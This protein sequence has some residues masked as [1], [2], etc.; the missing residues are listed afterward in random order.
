MEIGTKKVIG[1]L[2]GAV[3]FASASIALWGYLFPPVPDN[4]ILI[5]PKDTSNVS[6]TKENN[7]IDTEYLKANQL[8]I[9]GVRLEVKE[10]GLLVAN[11]IIMKN[12]GEI[13][14][15]ELYVVST[16]LDQGRINASGTIEGN[17][18]S[19]VVASAQINGTEIT[20]NG[21]DGARGKDGMDGANGAAGANG[22]DG[23]CKGF[24]GWSSAQPGLPGGNGED[25]DNG[26]DGKNGG[27]GGSIMI[28]TSYELTT[29]PQSEGGAGGKGGK[30]GAAGLGGKGGRGGSG[31]TGLGGSQDGK[32]SG[33]DGMDGKRGKGGLDGRNGESQLPTVKLIKFESVK[34]V[35]ER[36]MGDKQAFI[37]R[38]R[39]IRPEH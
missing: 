39:A 5:L 32:P 12:G 21:Q 29:T 36:T 14:G 37:S 3:G 25:G 23:S 28:L 11:E 24:G 34:K 30:G 8:V 38:L 18:G 16:R 26:V 20:S 10:G 19:I 22:R 6:V 27:N 15:P 2:V 13:Y 4:E 31:C 7:A 1:I 17:G 35:Y 9:D 33:A